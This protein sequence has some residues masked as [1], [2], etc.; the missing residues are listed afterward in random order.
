M[1]DGGCDPAKHRPSVDPWSNT[2]SKPGSHAHSKLP[3][4]VFASHLLPLA[5]GGALVHVHA[6]V[7]SIARETLGA[8]ARDVAHLSWIVARQSR[9]FFRGDVV[10]TGVVLAVAPTSA[11][12]RGSRGGVARALGL[13]VARDVTPAEVLTPASLAAAA[14]RVDDGGAA[15]VDRRRTRTRCRPPRLPS[16]SPSGRR[17]GKTETR[18]SPR[19]R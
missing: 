10:E 7:E 1:W 9:G 5:S 19:N 16:A 3:N 4:G 11:R 15:P 18:S 14:R 8:L 13:L 6:R 17:T 2:I 12:M